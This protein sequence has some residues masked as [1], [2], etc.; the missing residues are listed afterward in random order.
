MPVGERRL[1]EQTELWPQERALCAKAAEGSLL[2]LRSRRPREDDPLG[3]QEWSPRRQIRAQ[4]LFQLLTGQGP[5]LVGDAVAV[6][7]RG[8]Q[9]VGRLNL[10]GLSL[11][12]PLE[13]YDCYLGGRL[14]LAKAEAPDL[15]LRGSYLRERLSARQLGLTHALNLSRGFR[16]EGRVDLDRAHVG[17]LFL[18]YATVTGEMCLA[19]AH[20]KG[21]LDCSGARLANPDGNALN[22]DR[23][24]VDGDMLLSGARVTGGVRLPG[25]HI[26]GQLYCA[27][28]TLTKRGGLALNGDRLMVDGDM[29]LPDA[30][31]TGGVQLRGAQIKGQLY[32][33]GATLTKR[34]GLALNGDRLMVDGDMLLSGATVTGEMWLASAHIGSWLDCSRAT[35]KNEGGPALAGEGLTVDV[36]LFLSGARV[37]GGVRLPGAHIKG[38]LD[39]RRATLT[40][41]GGLALNGDRLMVD[42]DML[43]PDAA[44]TGG[45]QLRGAQI[46]GQLYCVGATLT[47]E[48]GPA[49]NGDRL[50]VDGDMLL[51]GATVTGEMWLAS[52]HIGSWL[53]CS[54]ATLK[55]EGGPALAGEGLTVDVNL[56]LSGATVTGEVR[57]PGAHIGDLELDGA[58]LSNPEGPAMDLKRASIVR[59]V[60]I[61]PISLQGSLDLTYARVGGWYD[62]KRTW[63][64]TL[65][66]EGFTYEIIKAKKPDDADDADEATVKDRLGWLRRHQSYLPQPYEQLATVYRKAGNDTAARTVWVAKQWARRADVRGWRHWPSLA[67]SIFL[68]W[69]IGYGYRPVLALIPLALLFFAGWAIF[70]A[71]HPEMLRPAESGAAQPGFNPV[72]YTADLLLP[73][74]NFGQRDAFVA[75]GWAAWASFGFIFAGW[76]LAAVVVVGLT[77]VFKRD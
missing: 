4:V 60:R 13:L 21:Q 66:L 52:A 10:G 50:M 32:C 53:D 15:S 75:H 73:V 17:D 27:G 54:R 64:T 11:R 34:G 62:E 36:N 69:T 3:G 23:L 67:W 19:G 28:A 76:L 61:R 33:V 41:R 47:N 44:V 37:T 51:S 38:L 58:T 56:F 42:G 9:I 2:D 70:D 74:A 35:L 8:A 45:V 25:A 30:A 63:P 18:S 55:N 12:C 46:K 68:R 26:K 65:H 6:R 20:I 39:C 29:L 5:S 77:G 57:L 43:L 72:R 71:A 24:M 1:L 16:C 22:G 31:V 59:S 7:L 40:N 49:L 48:G 14:D